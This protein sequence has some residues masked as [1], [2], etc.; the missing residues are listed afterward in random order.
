MAWIWCFPGVSEVESRR[1]L[2]NDC[3]GYECAL[4]SFETVT[5]E[6]CSRL[7]RCSGPSRS[8]HYCDYAGG[9]ALGRRIAAGW[10]AQGAPLGF[11]GESVCGALSGPNPTI[12]R[13]GCQTICKDR[14]TAR[15]GWASHFTARRD[16]SGYRP[17]AECGSSYAQHARLRRLRSSGDQS[18]GRMTGPL[19]ADEAVA[20]DH[21]T[22]RPIG[23]M[24]DADSG[25][26]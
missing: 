16:D 5:L 20:G 14:P 10:Q 15:Y 17:L 4:G 12:R 19:A 25:C 8:F 9:G 22:Q 7:A 24:R 23:A 26:R 13:A 18:L 11:G 21:E 3:P 1:T 6:S 2:H